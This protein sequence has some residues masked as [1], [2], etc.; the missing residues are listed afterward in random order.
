MFIIGTEYIFDNKNISLIE[1][2][3]G[4]NETNEN[5]KIKLGKFKNYLDVPM[6]GE[7]YQKA[8]F[9]NGDINSG[10]FN[11]VKLLHPVVDEFQKTAI[12]QL[13]LSLK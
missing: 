6:W 11:D 3:I 12:Q 9:D 8:I 13:S 1:N 2:Y 10:N 5:G 4:N 7:F